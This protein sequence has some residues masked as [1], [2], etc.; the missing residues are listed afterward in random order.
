MMFGK[1]SALYDGDWANNSR[2][3]E[4]KQVSENGDVY[5]GSWVENKREGY[6]RLTK[7]QSPYDQHTCIMQR[8]GA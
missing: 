5:E 7:V 3:G 6:G 2:H 8:I 4:G 1:G